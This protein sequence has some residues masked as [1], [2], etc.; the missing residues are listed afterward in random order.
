MSPIRQTPP[1]F[2]ISGGTLARAHSTRAGLSLPPPAAPPEAPHSVLLSRDARSARGVG[3][4][5][6]VNRAVYERR[7]RGEGRRVR[8][9]PRPQP[10][11]HFREAAHKLRAHDSNTNQAG[12]VMRLS[13]RWARG[14]VS[15]LC[16][17]RA[18]VPFEVKNLTRHRICSFHSLPSI[19]ESRRIAFHEIG[20]GFH[21]GHC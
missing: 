4:D 6:A 8:L 16:H 12:P 17:P 3:L 9:A 18:P 1:A 5:L 11:I 15:P 10:S 21:G 19:G 14:E 13:A 2:C 20:K 7:G